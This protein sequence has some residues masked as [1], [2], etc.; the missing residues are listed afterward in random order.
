MRHDRLL[1]RLALF[2]L[3]P[4]L[5]PSRRLRA[6]GAALLPLTLA[7]VL[8][9]CR[10]TVC[11]IAAA[12]ILAPALMAADGIVYAETGG[13]LSALRAGTGALIW[14]A[15]DGVAFAGPVTPV[16]ADCDVLVGTGPGTLSAF[17]RSDGSLAWRSQPVPH[18]Q[19]RGDTGTSLPVL[20]VADGVVYGAAS[21]ESL[22]AWR[23]TDGTLLWQ[24][25]PL[26]VPADPNYLS[27]FLPL[28]QPVV[29]GAV[30]FF[31]AGPS[32]HAVSA[33]DGTLLWSSPTLQTQNLYTPPVLTNGRLF[34]VADD[35]SLY[36]LRADSGAVLWHAPAAAGA[37]SVSSV[38][39]APSSAATA[40]A[41]IPAPSVVQGGV[42]YYT[43]VV[44]T[45]ALAADTSTLLWRQDY[46]ILRASLQ[47]FDITSA[48][49]VA[50]GLVYAP[51]DGLCALDAR[52]G[53]LR[54]GCPPQARGMPFFVAGD[55][56]YT[57]NQY[58]V[59][60]SRSSDGVTRWVIPPAFDHTARRIEQAAFTDD[61]IY[62]S[63][64][65][66]YTCGN[67]IL[68]TLTALRTTDGALL[69]QT[70][71]PVS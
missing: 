40:P 29:G 9:A 13:T 57:T 45:R 70:A 21:A 17:R 25:S 53:A 68:P 34:L 23:L 11:N 42:V 27:S 56:V 4:V 54:W 2:A 10:T 43:A 55:T 58:G 6:L 28:P 48:V 35:S 3:G 71:V 41:P 65:G 16:V 30:V 38:P 36:A 62:F 8:P 31:S 46:S 5:N 67:P 19:R 52:T 14:R 59:T 51:V 44:G 18:P 63:M 7:V 66:T 64:G 37:A 50:G 20:R 49:E 32:V 33:A 69:W 24:S 15:R 22:A 61:A 26:A 47:S 39:G 60:A 1:R 12:R